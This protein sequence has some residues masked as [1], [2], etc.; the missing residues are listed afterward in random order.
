MKSLLLV[1]LIVALSF[2]PAG[3][4]E[5]TSQE[6]SATALQPQPAAPPDRAP[7]QPANEQ[8]ATTPKPIAKVAAPVDKP[9]AVR[10]FEIPQGTAVTVLLTDPIST[11]KNKAGDA[12]KGTI[13]DPI[14]VNGETVVE[15]GA[16]VQGRVVDAEGAGRVK[17]TAN[18]RLALT[19]IVA[20]GK[21]Y[22]IVTRP[23][24]AEAEPTKGR[25]AGVI[26]GGGGIGAAIGALTGGKQGAVK[27][28]VIGGA[29]GTGAVLATKGKEVEFDAETKLKFALDQAAQMPKISAR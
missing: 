9:A 4:A 3:S 7:A 5:D 11:G 27:G 14:V 18:I 21:S 28:A 25:D 13:A 1:P 24:I 20:V 19:S 12:F 6:A 16:A 2:A 17:G 15:R 10:M 8:P 22:P 23:Y 29:A 26:A